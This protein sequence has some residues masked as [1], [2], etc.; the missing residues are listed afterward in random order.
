MKIPFILK[1]ECLDFFEFA[2]E[3]LDD[4][5]CNAVLPSDVEL[6][7]YTSSSEISSCIKQNLFPHRF[8]VL[9]YRM[10]R[11]LAKVVV[12]KTQRELIAYGWLQSW[13]PF[14]RVF[15][16]ISTQ[17]LMIGPAWTAPEWRGKG[18]HGLMLTKRIMI[19][20][21]VKPIFTFAEENN[22]ASISGIERVG[23]RK[24]AK[25]NMVRYFHVLKSAKIVKIR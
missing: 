15:A 1:K 24:I 5:D 2:G 11:G 21:K 17:G 8:S 3:T 9:Q 22:R 12:L 13:E 7:V 4:L 23:F 16:D 6:D 18:V 20:E 10:R 14:R 25:V 19:A